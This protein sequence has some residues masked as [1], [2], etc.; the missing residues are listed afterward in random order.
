MASASFHF[1]ATPLPEVLEALGQHYG[2]Q[3]T[4]TDRTRCLTGDFI[5]ESLDEILSMIED[6]L[7]VNISQN[8]KKFVTSRPDS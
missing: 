2:V 4:A 1:Y 8:G 6:V 7:G 5:G 3:L